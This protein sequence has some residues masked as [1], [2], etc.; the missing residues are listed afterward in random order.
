MFLLISALSK[1]KLIQ[2]GISFRP[3]S[4]TDVKG[5]TS[6]GSPGICSESTRVNVKLT[7]DRIVATE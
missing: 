1:L 2:V 6:Q 5:Y 4:V 3:D 7:D